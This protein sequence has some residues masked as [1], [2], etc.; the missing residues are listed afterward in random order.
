[1]E[2][3]N[4]YVPIDR[5]HALYTQTPLT[6]NTFGTA[7]F[8]DISDFTKITES[9]VE[10]LG[11]FRGA[12]E[13]TNL[14]NKVFTLLIDEIHRYG[15][16]VIGFSGDAITCWFDE[17]T[18]DQNHALRGMACAAALQ[19]AVRGFRFTAVNIN[20]V[21]LA[22]KTAAVS[23]P[24]LRLLVGSKDHHLVEALAGA[25]LTQLGQAEKLAKRGEIVV[26]EQLAME[27]MQHLKIGDWR[28][29]SS[30]QKVAVVQ[31]DKSSA[32]P[33]PWDSTATAHTETDL[34]AWLLPQLHEKIGQ[35]TSRFLAELR[36]IVATFVK[37]DGID[38]DTDPNA[39]TQL[40][41]FIQQIQII[42]AQHSGHL[43]QLTIGDK[44]SYVYIVWGAPTATEDDI[45]AALA[46]SLDIQQIPQTLPFINN[47]QI[48][49]SQGRVHAGAYGHPN[50]RTYGVLG[51]TVNM[52]ARLMSDAASGQILVSPEVKALARASFAFAPMGKRRFKGFAH[53]MDTYLL[54]N[55]AVSS[56]I[57]SL[58]STELIGRTSEMAQV[59]TM[60]DDFLL[61]RSSQNAIISGEP[62]IGKSQLTAE[63]QR[64]ADAIGIKTAVGISN[65]IE[66]NAPYHSWRDIFKKL[67]IGDEKRPFA[68]QIQQH[69]AEIAPYQQN[70][71]P[72]LNAVLLADTP[73]NELTKQMSGQVRADNT[74]GLLVQ[75]LIHAAEQNPLMLILEDAH[76]FDSASWELLRRVSYEV[77]SLFI[78]LALRPL[79]APVPEQ[80]TAFAE[81]PQTKHLALTTMTEP[82]I[83]TMICQKLGVQTL[84]QAVT[85]LIHERAEGHPFFSEEL[86]YSLRD[87]QYIT[88]E[89]GTC[90]PAQALLNGSVVD[91]PDTIQGVIISRLDRLNPQEQLALKVA[92]VIG[93]LFDFQTLHDVY[94]E[95]TH[96]PQ[97]KQYLSQ[98][99]SQNITLIEQPEPTLSY[100]FK[101]ALTHDIAYGLL[102]FSQKQQLHREV[103]HWYERAFADDLSPAYPILA[104]H[105]QRAVDLN[106]PLEADLLK[107]I[108]FLEKA[109]EQA[110]N[111]NASKETIQYLETTLQLSQLLATPVSYLQ[112]AKWFRLL[113]S[114]A[115][116]LG[117]FEQSIAFGETGLQILGESIPDGRIT[118]LRRLSGQILQQVP[119]RLAK[120][121][122][123]PH[124]SD[125]D[126]LDDADYREYEICEILNILS[127]IFYVQD[128]SNK[129]F[130]AQLMI[131]NH[132]EKMKVATPALG[133]GFASAGFISG[134]LQQQKLAHH[135]FELAQTTARQLRHLPTIEDVCRVN[136]LY[137]VSIGDWADAEKHLEEALSLSQTIGNRVTKAGITMVQILHAFFQGGFEQGMGRAQ[138]LKQLGVSLGNSVFELW[139][140]NMSM[141]YYAAKHDQDQLQNSIDETYHLLAKSLNLDIDQDSARTHR[142]FAA[143]LA[144]EQ[145]DDNGLAENFKHTASL[146]ETISPA[147]TGQFVMINQV[148]EL[149]LATRAAEGVQT[150]VSPE[151]LSEATAVFLKKFKSFAAIQLFA[152]PR[153]HLFNG[154]LHYLNGDHKKAVAQ[155]QKA[156]D[157]AAELNMPYDQALTQYYLGKYALVPGA[158][159]VLSEATK[160][161]E[162]FGASV[163]A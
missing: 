111:A 55:T 163:H 100:M 27:Y 132:A 112:Q 98:L 68:P 9:L 12:E 107:A 115:F 125:P 66:R 8:A 134:L 56:Q 151:A 92:S 51:K 82:A 42:V 131:L 37:F 154:R 85:S 32:L 36:P 135:Y 43:L 73:E 103:A 45:Q 67:I 39:S 24:A 86:A 21:S 1:M 150:A 102:L 118:F 99:D 124:T 138:T 159:Q 143:L 127:T 61:H 31:I 97:L 109:A 96:Q 28:T 144:L 2:T 119:R 123:L 26:S 152:K 29:D 145:G 113:C 89:N 49:M 69:L 147:R 30:G 104:H 58:S 35:S 41:Q 38:Y 10:A 162:Q 106:N 105:W 14:L 95:P 60:L 15:G 90:V 129:L 65:N 17:A 158:N 116:T 40:D 53:E 84:P 80:F 71:A 25:T 91:F 22:L 148:G 5:R 7:L 156:A 19:E 139:A 50:R 57:T 88:I 3:I 87:N 77:D 136:G 133:R 140:L 157:N 81:H 110:D 155:F 54:E 146:I 4:A 47:I 93:R 33:T 130:I 6:E 117:D 126:E 76:W 120:R 122:Q 70:L 137:S 74:N 64:Q 48:G 94:P 18:H 121:A 59:Q 79:A 52:A 101:H 114:A 128:E 20:T 141:A 160:Q 13:L 72:L 11:A 44:G 161:L 78:V 153:W 149:L 83:E 75:I 108:A 16:A 46:A 63:V 142:P 23:G 62:G 34:R